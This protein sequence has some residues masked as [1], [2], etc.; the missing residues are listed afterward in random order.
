MLD[1]IYRLVTGFEREHG[2]RPNLLYINPEHCKYLKSS[3][4]EKYSMTEIMDMLNME[5]IIDAGSVHPHVCWT[6][7]AH[8][9][10]S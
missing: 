10:A 7:A 4:D 5:V 8:R 3:F 9:L 2:M 1:Y 6:Q